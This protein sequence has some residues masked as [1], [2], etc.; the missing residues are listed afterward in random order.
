MPCLRV[1]RTLARLLL[2]DVAIEAELRPGLVRGR[3]VA[4]VMDDDIFLADRAPA[5]AH[6]LRDA[7]MHG[8]AVLEAP[9]ATEQPQQSNRDVARASPCGWVAGLDWHPPPRA[10]I[11]AVVCERHL[12][13]VRAKAIG[14]NHR[15]NAG[16]GFGPHN[17]VSVHM[18]EPIARRVG[19]AAVARLREVIVPRDSY[20]LGVET[21]RDLNR[22]VVGP[23][24][25]DHDLISYSPNA[26]QALSQTRRF[27]LDDH[28]D[29]EGRYSGYSGFWILDFGFSVSPTGGVSDSGNPESKI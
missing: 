10:H 6:A 5:F 26:P 7:L 17:L 20:H 19:E 4:I 22:I 8:F 12:D 3:V 16:R 13:S 11:I 25:A 21:Q 2:G 18:Q 29:A 14:V 23:R 1:R 15:P 28:H 27:V 9:A 24:V